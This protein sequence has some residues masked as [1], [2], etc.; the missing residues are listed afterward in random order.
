[1]GGQSGTK[2]LLIDGFDSDGE[3]AVNTLDTGPNDEEPN[4]LDLEA[5]LR[6]AHARIADH[7]IK[8]HRR[9]TAPELEA[10][11]RPFPDV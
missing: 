2:R 1:M 11:C 4:R 10:A 6:D 8:L 7:C 3:R 9:T 5:G